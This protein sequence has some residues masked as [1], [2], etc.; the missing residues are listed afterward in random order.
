MSD[1]INKVSRKQSVNSKDLSEFADLLERHGAVQVA[2]TLRS[3][4]RHEDWRKVWG[5]IG[6]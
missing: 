2:A 5:V 1:K 4:I 3:M 6:A